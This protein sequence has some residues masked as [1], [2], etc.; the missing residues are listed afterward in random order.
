[1]LVLSLLTASALTGLGGG[2][3]RASPSASLD[4]P[5]QVNTVVR[6]F[7]LTRQTA[8]PLGITTDRSG[9]VWFAEDNYDLITEFIPVNSTFRSYAIPTAHHLA[10]IWFLVFDEA[11]NLWFADNSQSLLWEF[12]PASGS[13]SNFTADGAYPFAL[14]YVAASGR[15]WFTSVTTNQV[16]YFELD[17]G[18]ATLGPVVT[19]QGTAPGPGPSGVAVDIAGDAYVSETFEARIVELN[20]STMSVV[21][22]WQLPNGSQPVG[23][24]MDEA[25]GRLWFTNHASSFFGYVSLGSPALREFPTSLSFY[26]GSSTVTLPYWIGLDGAGNVWLDEHIG[27]RIARFDP[28][29]LQLT[30]FPITANESSPLRFWVDNPSGT[31]WFTQFSG[32][33]IGA[34]PIDSDAA[35]KVQT[36][37]ESILLNPE[38][39]FTVDAAPSAAGSPGV[40]IASGITGTPAPDFGASVRPNGQG[41]EVQVTAVS[42][43]PGNYTAGVCFS[44]S[45]SNQCGYVS[46]S[47]AA[48]GANNLLF[49][50][51]YLGIGAALIVLLLG[52]RRE[53]RRRGRRE[54]LERRASLRAT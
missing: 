31:V 52:L 18:G 24:A 10:W 3:G 15:I 30:E 7:N 19:L 22:T 16:G 51:L 38:A 34:I 35:Q 32:N 28:N 27:N 5:G 41:Y 49:G 23:L 37:A 46:L 53:S 39:S 54:E 47:V 1:L 33:A 25:D 17:G 43:M 20:S 40:S 50:L 6:T 14:D 42:A 45:S 36:P 8:Y 26:Q 21:R 4:A 9:N 13:F 48:P 11:G 2:P 29:S 12:S 44:Y